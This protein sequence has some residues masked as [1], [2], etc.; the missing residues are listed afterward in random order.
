LFEVIRRVVFE[1]IIIRRIVVE[2]VVIRV[3]FF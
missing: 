2:K 1:E 3:E